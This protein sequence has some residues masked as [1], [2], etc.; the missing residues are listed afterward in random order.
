[1]LTP[2]HRGEAALMQWVDAPLA[3]PVRLACVQFQPPSGGSATTFQPGVFLGEIK[4]SKCM[5][6]AD[7][8][9]G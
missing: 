8:G 5:M 2:T 9:S 7:A 1:M 4:T 3:H 6:P